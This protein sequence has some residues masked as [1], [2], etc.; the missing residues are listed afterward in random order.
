MGDAE[1]WVGLGTRGMPNHP[2]VWGPGDA[3]P[4][5]GLGLGLC[6]PHSH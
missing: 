6:K 3:E 4:P 2:R 5:T 1:L